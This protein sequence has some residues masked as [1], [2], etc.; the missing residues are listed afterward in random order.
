MSAYGQHGKPHS[1]IGVCATRGRRLHGHDCTVQSA[2]GHSSSEVGNKLGFNNQRHDDARIMT[3]RGVL[4]LQD[5]LFGFTNRW[6]QRRV[7]TRQLRGKLALLQLFH[8]KPPIETP[9]LSA[10]LHTP[11]VA[12]GCV[13]EINR[14]MLDCESVCCHLWIVL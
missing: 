12:T 7:S 13:W 11:S 2:P 1:L 8:P 3:E 6:C 4:C 5:C 9:R 10:P 14:K